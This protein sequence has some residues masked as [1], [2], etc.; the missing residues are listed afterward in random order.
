MTPDRARIRARTIWGKNGYVKRTRTEQGGFNCA[1]G[2]ILTLGD[3]YAVFQSEGSGPT[4]EDAFAAYEAKQKDARLH[5]HR[6]RLY[7]AVRKS[8]EFA[9]ALLD[10]PHAEAAA[11]LETE[12]TML[13][14]EIEGGS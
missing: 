7:E 2:K 14:D 3:N 11:N 8:R 13:I 4:F 6:G 9:R 12:L 1:V 10:G 5:K